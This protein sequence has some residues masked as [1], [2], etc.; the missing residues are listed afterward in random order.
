MNRQT[1]SAKFP[2]NFLMVALFFLPLLATACGSEA[3]GPLLSG[4]PA[5]AGQLDLSNGVSALDGLSISYRVGQPALLS[6]SIEGSNGQSYQLRQNDERSTGD[7][8]LRLSGA[9][10]QTEANLEQTRLLAN[11]TYRYILKAQ[12]QG[13]PATAQASGTF[14]VINRPADSDPPQIDD[15]TGNPAVISPNFDARD[16]TSIIGWRTSRPAT[17]TVSVSNAAGFNRILKTLKNEPAQ[18]DKVVFDGLDEKGVPLTDGVYTYTVQAADA[19]GN[20]SRRA[21][22]LEIKGGGT[23]TASIVQASIGPTSIIKGDLITVTLRVKNTGKVPIRSQGPGSGYTYNF[24]DTYSSIEGGKYRDAAGF[25]RVGV[26]YESNSGGGPSRYPF[27]WGFGDELQPGQEVEVVG[28]IRVDRQ[29]DKL[30]FYA[31]LI[32]E[33]VRLPQDHIQV[34][35]VNI[36]Y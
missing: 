2:R 11:G 9:I 20:V 34:T 15:L 23:P 32:E 14:Q 27:R 12:A 10:N 28:L 6:A 22:Q 36:G 17:V 24:N 29:E 1:L 31:G 30:K 3:S 16:D 33:Q 35:V 19:W 26:D 25:W 13:G 18:T 7:Y 8:S 21:G 4:S 5:E